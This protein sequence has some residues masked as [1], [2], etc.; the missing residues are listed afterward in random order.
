VFYP[1]IHNDSSATLP[2]K[3]LK[4]TMY[5]YLL[6]IHSIIRWLLVTGILYALLQA[7]R[8]LAGNKPYSKGDNITRSF[9]SG[10][11][12]IQLLLGF[13]L[14]MKSPLVAYFRTHTKEAMQYEDMSFFGMY[15]ISMMIVAILL[16]TIGA[17]KAKRAE[18]DRGKHR[19]ILIWLGIAAVVIF[20]AIPWP[21]SPV[22]ARPYWRGF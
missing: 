22:V 3:F 9:V 20:L 5:P 15:H 12:H 14:Y 17:A 10:V 19:Q 2:G 11:S 4:E 7:I 6:S 16:I 1:N 8:G 13:T 18:G 21:F